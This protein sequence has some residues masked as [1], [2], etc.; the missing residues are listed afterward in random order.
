MKI[1]QVS[2]VNSAYAFLLSP[3]PAI[4]CSAV[5]QISSGICSRPAET[6][7]GSN[8]MVKVPSSKSRRSAKM[9][10]EGANRH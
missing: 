1:N 4:L 9:Q 8:R 6:G 3:S 2:E 10:I 7:S 5:F